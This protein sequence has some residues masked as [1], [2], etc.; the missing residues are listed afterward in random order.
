MDCKRWE[1]GY[2]LGERC[3]GNSSSVAQGKKAKVGLFGQVGHVGRVGQEKLKGKIRRSAFAQG[4]GVTRPPSL[5]LWRDRK[6]QRKI[7]YVKFFRGSI[8]T[9]FEFK[10]DLQLRCLFQRNNIGFHGFT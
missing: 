3:A 4:Y 1:K 7:G 2:N 9:L 8:K 10:M 6:K 5:K